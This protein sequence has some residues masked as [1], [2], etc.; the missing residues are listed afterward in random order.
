MGDSFLSA[1]VIISCA[2]A[3]DRFQLVASTEAHRDHHQLMQVCSF[4]GHFAPVHAK[5][6][7]IRSTAHMVLPEEL[8]LLK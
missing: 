4:F 1:V 2:V 8:L 6:A 3:L 7:Q 5:D